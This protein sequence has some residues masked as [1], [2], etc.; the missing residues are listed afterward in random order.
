[1]LKLLPMELMETNK[2]YT[3]TINLPDTQ[4]NKPLKYHISRYIKWTLKHIKPYA[5]YKLYP[6][7]SKNGKLHYHGNI[8]FN[9]NRNIF[10]FYLHLS[11]Q[12]KKSAI[13]IDTIS[14]PEKWNKYITKQ[15]QYKPQYEELLLPYTLS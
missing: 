6:E 13:E 5:Q 12:R 7:L 9:T 2:E 15:K 14:D 10:H 1:M 11:D 4:I 8:S 3:L